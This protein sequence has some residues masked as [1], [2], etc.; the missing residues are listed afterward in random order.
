MSIK[1]TN[2]K[3]IACDYDCV[4]KGLGGVALPHLQTR[5]MA[6]CSI[7]RNPCRC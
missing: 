1:K 3:A 4:N 6:A 2:K 5:A 7:L